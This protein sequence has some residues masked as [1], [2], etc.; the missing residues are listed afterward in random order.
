MTPLATGVF[1]R[2]GESLG[3][4]LP[5]LG[6]ALVVLIVG[7]LATRI[8]GRLLVRLL[9]RIGVDGLA[10]RSGVHDVLVNAGLERSLAWLLGVVFRVTFAILVVFT[11]LSMSGVD[12]LD[13][14]TDEGVLFVPR[15]AAALGL[16]L[17]G[18][19]LGGIARERVD[20]MAYQMDLRG[21]LGNVAQWVVL[22]VAGVM[23]L[24]QVGVPTQILTVLAAIVLGGGVLTGAIA[25]GL[26]GRQLAGAVS[27][28][29]YVQESFAVGQVVTVAGI[30][31]EIV[32]VER[33]AAILV[34]DGEPESTI[35]V[36]HHL[37]LEAPVRVDERAVRPG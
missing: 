32:A 23:A 9:R 11:A 29:R 4:V 7:L 19:V 21:P 18:L 5:S 13:R 10:E 33:A 25:F 16:A 14:A 27:A 12:A 2:A 30:R 31:G 24:S 20:R 35:R 8:L 1:E 28:G 22:G 15:L 17:A 26:G 3:E 34:P 37:F 6:G 36:P